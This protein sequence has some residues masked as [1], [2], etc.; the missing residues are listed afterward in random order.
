MISGRTTKLVAALTAG[1][2]LALVLGLALT[3]HGSVDHGVTAG[4][5][6]QVP[7][8]SINPIV[9]PTKSGSESLDAAI[10]GNADASAVRR[11]IAEQGGLTVASGTAC[12]QIE[13]GPMYSQV[14][15]TEGPFA[16]KAVWAPAIHTRGG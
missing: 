13:P 16:G 11:V 8:S 1:G 15:V 4:C 5:K 7:N 3:R 6:L 14:L 2:L 12:S 9:F 10:M